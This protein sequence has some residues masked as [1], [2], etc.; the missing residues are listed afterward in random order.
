MAMSGHN[1]FTP[2]GGVR[3][4]AW[5]TA[6]VFDCDGLLIDSSASWERAF[7]AEAQ[8]AGDE[9]TRVQ[10]AVLLGSSVSTAAETLSEMLGR[11]VD[12]AALRRHV[13]VAFADADATPLA[14]AQRL[15]AQLS[16]RLTL[17]VATNGPPEVVAHALERAGLRRCFDHIV[18][19]E[20]VPRAKPAPDVYLEACR[21]L[22]VDPSQAVAFED[23]PIGLAAAHSAGL[24]TIGIPSIPRLS[25]QA[26]LVAARLDDSNIASLLGLTADSA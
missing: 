20:Q 2:R 10:L 7:C 1:N 23:S 21:R 6:A 12:R 13:L 14:G 24:L 16:G 9:L 22:G 17:A 11:H 8:E 18:S 5:P 26:D 4:D 25:L 15:L 3:R 19:A